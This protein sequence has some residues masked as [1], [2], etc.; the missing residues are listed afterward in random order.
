MR[1]N[2]GA[3]AAHN[4][5]AHGRHHTFAQFGSGTFSGVPTLLSE[6][7]LVEPL[8]LAAE[9]ER[10]AR[11]G[12]ADPLSLLAVDGRAL[13]TTPIHIAANRAREE[14]RGGETAAYALW[15][16]APRVADCRRPAVLRRK[17][18]ALTAH[19]RPLLAASAHR[20]EPIELLWT[21]TRLSAR[22]YGSPA[23]G[24][25]AVRAAR[26]AGV[27]GRAGEGPAPCRVV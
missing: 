7:M 14:A 24:S 1:F 26:P 21:R 9:A 5:V 11:L 17:L 12:V 2:G 3:Q 6:H 27:R 8:A 18:R 19:Y 16:D 23:P 13:L 4:V 22:P 20:P 25:R 10:L 15:H